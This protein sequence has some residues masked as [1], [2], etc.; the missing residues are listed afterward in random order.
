M[1]T[2]IVRRRLV[3]KLTSH[4]NSVGQLVSFGLVNN[5]S[6]FLTKSFYFLFL[7]YLFLFI[8]FNLRVARPVS[9]DFGV[10]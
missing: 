8:N 3:A 1:L 9:R 7:S 10:I 4:C 6:T 2:C 5:L